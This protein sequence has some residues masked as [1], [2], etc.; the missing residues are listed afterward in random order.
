MDIYT[1]AAQVIGYR[2]A[3]GRLPENLG[4]ALAETGS[5]EGLIYAL[6]PDGIFEITGERSGQVVVYVSTEP[7]TQFVASS[8]VAVRGGAGS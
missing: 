2:D 4:E 7:L 1:V 5:A 8:W 6:G 3:N